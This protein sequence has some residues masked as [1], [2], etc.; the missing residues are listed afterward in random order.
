MMNTWY[1]VLDVNKNNI[2]DKNDLY[3][4]P[5]ENGEFY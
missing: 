1:I 5:N 2:E 3:F 4:Y